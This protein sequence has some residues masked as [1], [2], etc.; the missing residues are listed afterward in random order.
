MTRAKHGRAIAGRAIVAALLSAALTLAISLYGAGAAIAYVT[1]GCEYDNDSISPVE[2]RFFS[3]G[4]A[5][6]TAFK[7][8]EAAWD[9]TASPGHFAEDS[10]SLDPEINVTDGVFSGSWW[11]LTS[12]GCNGGLYS[13]NETNTKFDTDGMA[14]LT[15]TEKKIVAEHEIGDSYGLG[16]TP[17]TGCRVMRQGEHKF[18]CGTM[19]A[20]DDINGVNAVY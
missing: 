19:P 11:A 18:T 8:A 17:Q 12:W 14:D 15:A 16:D 5:Y 3:V 10:S 13:G 1:H 9:A 4:S 20:A 6:E 7:N 2:Y